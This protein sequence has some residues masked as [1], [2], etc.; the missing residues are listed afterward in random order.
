MARKPR[1]EFPGA[2]YHV[3]ARGNNKQ[4]IFCSEKDYLYYLKRL[5]IAK[6]RYDFYL[7]G[8]CLMPNHLHLL[9]QTKEVALS[10]I[11]RTVQ[12]SYAQYFNRTNK[13]KGH[14]FDS[15]YKPILCDADRYLLELMRY[16][17]LNPV[18]AGITRMPQQYQWSS[19]QT[20]MGSSNSIVDK[21][22]ILGM[23]GKTKAE[24]KR[25]LHRFTLE[26][27]TEG[28]ED[29]F[30]RT[31]DQ[32]FLGDDEFVYDI[33]S[34]LDNSSEEKIELGK[35]CRIDIQDFLSLVA[36][37][38]HL[39]K[40]DI[41]SST[42]AKTVVLARHIFIYVARERL[43]F[44]CVEIARFLGKDDSSTSRAATKI[45]ERLILDNNLKLLID[46]LC[47]HLY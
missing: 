34:K 38:F 43:G 14:V 22:L 23:F 18:R 30:Y 28:S 10:R 42:K 4:I 15:R 11:M 24:A 13:R 36:K 45:R 44:S 37:H 21:D 32:R 47:A 35:T 19:Y 33:K 27:V 31:I 17:H 12:T 39:D 2:L 40:S 8:F 1:V 26:R 16:I 25:R 7:Y 5:H 3:M 20:Y 46:D 9:I 41:L 29:N 6:K